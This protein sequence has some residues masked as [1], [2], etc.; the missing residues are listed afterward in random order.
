MN[1]YI[2]KLNLQLF[3]IEDIEDETLLESEEII[4]D[5]EDEIEDDPE[6]SE[7]DIED[8]LEEDN[9]SIDKKTKSIIKHK[10]ENKELK[11]QLQELQEK[12]QA[13]ELEAET[14]NRILELTKQGK[15]STEAT[16][17]ATN[18]SEVKSLRMKIAN[19]ELEKLEDKYPGIGTYSKKLA[20]DKAKMP[21]FSYE[22]I[23]L[24]NYSKQS[25]FE[26]KTRLE[27]E[28]AHR[29]KSAQDKSLPGS[30]AKQSQSTTLSKEDERVY[31]YIRKSRPNMTRKQFLENLSNREMDI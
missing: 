21:E 22:Q 16:S 4:D 2:P 12:V 6:E 9:P 3:A 15:T 13:D 5:V 23:Y 8:D 20:E 29:N 25:E 17:I 14:N 18:E 1:M 7:E 28:I 27:Q 11:R 24:V 10:K 19:M 30:T 26:R 31:Q